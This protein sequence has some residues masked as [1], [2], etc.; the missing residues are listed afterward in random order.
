MHLG[1]HRANINCC[2]LCDAN[3]TTRKRTDFRIGLAT[4]LCTIW[5]NESNTAAHPDRHRLFRHVPGAGV[6]CFVPDWLHTKHIGCDAYFLGGILQYMLA[7]MGLPGSP[8]EILKMIWQELRDAYNKLKLNKN[9]L[10][11]LSFTMVQSEGAKLPCLKA[12]GA[13]I[14]SAVPAISLVFAKYANPDDEQHADILTCLGYTREI[15]TILD[16]NSSDY[17]LP[18]LDAARLQECCWRFCQ[19]IRKLVKYFHPRNMNAFHYTLK[20]HYLVH[21]G[22]V[23]SYMNPALGSCHS[24]EDL[25]KIVKRLISHSAVGA[26][27]ATALKKAMGRY[28]DG[29]ALDLR[30]L[31][32]VF[33]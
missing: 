30:G 6:N 3:S 15:D 8:A 13:Q 22:M 29:L 31:D 14:K 18:P 19:Y 1:N 11:S 16:S 24:G 21:F 2:G 12:R 7:Y 23:V 20:M 4:W 25:M 5:N 32:R 33:P 28:A 26:R 10:W 17:V 9:R 27:P